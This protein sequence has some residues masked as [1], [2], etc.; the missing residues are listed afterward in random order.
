MPSMHTGS[1]NED[2]S[3]WQSP[4]DLSGYP[5]DGTQQQAAITAVQNTDAYDFGYDPGPLPC[6]QRRLRF[7]SR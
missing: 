5:P 7:Q 3:T 4:G 2:K 6:S 1:V